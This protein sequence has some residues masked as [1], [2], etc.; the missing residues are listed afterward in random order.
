MSMPPPLY[1]PS[2]VRSSPFM[3]PKSP[4]SVAPLRQTT[5][6]SSPTKHASS[7]IPPSHGFPTPRG[8]VTVEDAP[9]STTSSPPRITGTTTHGF[10]LRPTPRPMSSSGGGVAPH[11]NALSKLQ[12]SQVRAMR[13]AFQ[14][15][16]RDSDGMV[17][18]EDV[19]DMLNQLGLPSTPADVAHFF[20]PSSPSTIT[21]AV[22]LNSIASSLVELSPSAELLNAF[23]AFDDDDSGQIDVA[24]LRDA[25]LHTAPEPGQDKL[26][27]LDV[28][29]VIAGF[30]GRRAFGRSNTVLGSATKRG[31]VFRYQEFVNTINGANGAGDKAG[32]GAEGA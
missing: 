23:S 2:P 17:N 4:A 22:F 15:L 25:L 5:P 14:I 6:S 19:V 24:E 11:G 18:R 26:T 13:E 1:K 7:P 10:P 30:T 9:E 21:M 31:E 20:P 3:R 28:E 27:A 8:R 29:K 32:E 12:P 16:D